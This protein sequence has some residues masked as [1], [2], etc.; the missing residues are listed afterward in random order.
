MRY[1]HTKKIDK[2]DVRTWF[3]FVFLTFPH[4]KPGYIAQIPVLDIVFDGWKLISFLIV[5]IWLFL[6]S[7]ERISKLMI[8]IC[9]MEIYIF[10]VTCIRGGEVQKS[11][12]TMASVISIVLLYDV[13]I[14]KK[15]VF[16]ASQLFCFEVVIYI[17]LLTEIIYPDTMYTVQD[18]LFNA[19]KCWFL[20]YYNN[21]SK[22]FIPALLFA[23]CYKQET[24]KKVRSYCLMSAVVLSV[25]LVWSGGVF[26][27]VFA[28]LFAYVILKNQANIFNYYTYWMIHIVFFIGIIELKLQNLFRWLIDDLLGKWNSMEARMSLWEKSMTLISSHPIVGHGI[29]DSLSRQLETGIIWGLHCH[30]MVMEVLYEGGII[31]L[32]WFAI[33]VIIAGKRLYKYRNTME[34]K[35]ISIAFLGWCVAT[36]VEPFMSPFLMGMFVV[37][38]YSNGGTE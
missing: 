32:V 29:W 23:F 35:V 15:R 21:H 22:W 16:Y 20:G 36:L 26:L 12:V 13:A 7:R 9:F 19:S 1:V 30:N 34:S 11:F 25:F 8:G 17:N 18:G 38:Y 14:K 24:G 28:M 31:Y 33:I 37:A 27:A 2:R 10:L 6:F 5:G 4:L 3:L